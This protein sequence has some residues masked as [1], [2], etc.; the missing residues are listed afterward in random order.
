M[1]LRPCFLIIDNEFAG[2]ISTRKLVI[3][4]AKYNVITAYSYAEAILTLER[5]PRVHATVLTADR[6]GHADAFLQHVRKAYPEIKRVVTGETLSSDLADRHVESYSPERLL[7]TLRELFP[8]SS[9][10][11]VEHEVK[12]EQ[13]ASD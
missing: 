13:E 3:E 6:A 10:V 12:L 11:L 5:F 7:Q 4:T 1:F 9:T 2:S 8:Q